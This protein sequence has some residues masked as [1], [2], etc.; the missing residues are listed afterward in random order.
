VQ[1]PNWDGKLW[2]QSREQNWMANY[3]FQTTAIKPGTFYPYTFEMNV[4][5]YTVLAGHQLALM[6]FGSDPEY[7][8]RPFNATGFKVEIGPDT[9]LSLPLVT[10]HGITVTLDPNG[11]KVTPDTI[12]VILDDVYG[13]LPTPTLAG[14]DFTGWNTKEDGSG[15]TVTATTTVADPKPHTLFAQ[16]KEITVGGGGGGGGST[17]A[18]ISPARADFDIKGGKDISVTLTLN[19]RKIN[20][21][22]NGAYTLKEGT[23]YTVSGNKVTIKAGYLSTLKTGAQTITFEMNGGV[24]PRLTVTVKD[25]SEEEEEEEEEETG[26]VYKPLAP[27]HDAGTK[28][29]ATKTNNVLLLD[30]E[31]LDFPAVKIADYNWLK[32]RDFAMLLN[33]TKKQFSIS[34]DAATNIID[35]RTGSS[36]QPLGDELENTLVQTETAIASPQRLRVNGEFIATAAYNIKGY[37]YF[38]LRDLAIILNFAVEYDDASGQITLNLDEPYQE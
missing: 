29:D 11:G 20:A 26:P 36:Y 4:M 3:E 17:N 7:T 19:G 37:N 38:R 2:Y 1:N 27:L 35:I 34:Y 12:V 10:P 18:S 5:E 16:W 21:L 28:V 30:E 8:I 31:E 9:Y 14:H 22:K 32:L 13:T 33:K 6:I 24:N 15:V 25:T 23:D